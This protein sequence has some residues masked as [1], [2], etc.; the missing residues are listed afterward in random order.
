MPWYIS[1]QL[2]SFVLAMAAGFM[3]NNVCDAPYDSATKNPISEGVCRKETVTRLSVL[4]AAFSIASFL[5]FAE[6]LQSVLA[7]L[8]YIILWFA[9]SGAGIRLKETLAGPFVA[10]WVVWAGGPAVLL[11]NYRLDERPLLLLWISLF[12]FYCG[13]EINHQLGDYE[14]DRARS[15]KTFSVRVGLPIA[16]IAR[17]S[18]V[19]ASMVF[20]SWTI[21]PFLNLTYLGYVSVFIALLLLFGLFELVLYPDV[22]VR[23]IR[24]RSLQDSIGEFK[25]TSRRSPFIMMK[26][27]LIIF[28]IVSVG[29]GI[30][31]GLAMLW[32]LVTSKRT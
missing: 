19:V 18:M 20:M 27:L 15:V 32:I 5:P 2:V 31:I 4:V 24:R 14:E 1:L 28:V 8:L 30:W 13:N 7:L 9:Y 29:I 21:A 11:I 17:Y 22:L 12:L 25:K 16:I 6:S 10:S 26:L 3:Y 23:F